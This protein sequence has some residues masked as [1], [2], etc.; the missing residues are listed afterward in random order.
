M[1]LPF[2]SSRGK[3]RDQIVSIDLGGR[4]TKAVHLQRRGDRFMLVDYSIVDA[5]I[6]DKTL[7][8]EILTDHLRNVGRMLGNGKAKPV[9]LAISV[10]ESL[11]RQIE[12]PLMPADDLRLMLKFN[13]KTYLQQDLSD[14]VFDCSYIVPKTMD[15]KAVN[16]QK[17]RLM[18]GAARKQTV[19]DLAAA[20]KAAGMIPDQIVPGLIGPI[21]AFEFAEPD[22][23]CKETV[24]LVDLGF[25]NSFI[26]IADG[27]ELK[28][29][30]VVGIGGDRIT[31]GL[32]ETM[33]ISY[34]EA[35]NIKIG[36]PMEVQPN[37]EALI[38]PLGRELRASIDFFEHQND[39]A[40]SQVYVSG[41]ATRSE[42]V[43]Q[44]LQAELMVPCKTWN[45]ARFLQ[46][47]LESHKMNEIEQVAP[48]LTVAI[49][50][51]TSG[52]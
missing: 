2:L 5:P 46:M 6:F 1:E 17:H 24:A 42:F 25:K 49:G 16:S 15:P 26:T 51:A 10:T 28:L 13:S 32:A 35:E 22:A 20:V 45:P 41:G 31:S 11:L 19:D 8:V 7:S 9:T 12:A 52:F 43:L 21:N 39:K 38:S 47:G 14:H 36:M 30:R 18:V 27:G 23:F 50:A 4:T 29:N 3:K 44:A 40:I 34:V 48:Q 33:N 37:L